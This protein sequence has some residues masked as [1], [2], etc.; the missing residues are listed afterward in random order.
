MIRVA[1]IDDHPVTR[2]G[3]ESILAPAGGMTVTLSADSPPP[4][5][6]L[7]ALDADVIIHDLYLA[8]DTPA[9]A[10][11]T[12]LSALS[13]VLVMS[14]YGRPADVLAAVR[15]GARG[16]LT[17]DSPAAMY[18]SAVETVATGGFVLSAQ[19]ADI[20]RAALDDEQRPAGGPVGRATP[21]VALSPRE[22]ET[23]ELIAS[24]FT[25]QQV[26]RRMGV[27]KATIDTYVERIRT[28]LHVGNK[29]EL[30]RAALALHSGD[31]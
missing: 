6:A 2:C 31:G 10:S 28:K 27:S 15:A 30:T 17:K 9:T 11:I 29:A 7:E 20:L 12:R 13:A 3:V 16:Y 5:D 4:D 19:L 26:A 23:L 8:D 18:I 25:H 14:A 21:T 1:I 24:G 22:S